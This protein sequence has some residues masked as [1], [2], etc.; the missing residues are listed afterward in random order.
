[1]PRATLTG[2][3]A[4]INLTRDQLEPGRSTNLFDGLDADGWLSLAAARAL[5]RLDRTGSQAG[6]RMAAVSESQMTRL[7]GLARSDYVVA[8]AR[9]DGDRV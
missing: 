8:V 9:V 1:M 6:G 2:I 4:R 3:T 5:L 7:A